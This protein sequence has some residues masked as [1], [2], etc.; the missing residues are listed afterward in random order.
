MVGPSLN[1]KGGMASLLYI[2]NRYY[3]DALNL[4]FI[5]TYFGEGRMKD[6]LY[7]ACAIIR[8]FCICLLDKKVCFHIHVSSG[9][10]YVRKSIIANLCI[11]FGNK[12]VLHIHAG[13]FHDFLENRSDSSK[14]KIIRLL[15]RID[16]IIVLSN[17]WYQYI[18]KYISPERVEIIENPAVTLEEDRT[19]G[20]KP[21]VHILFVGDIC[22]R[23]GVYDLVEAV[24]CLRYRNIKVNIYGNGDAGDLMEAIRE[25]EL[26]DIVSFRGWVPYACIGN[27]Y[28][29]TDIFVLPSY[30]EGLPMSILEAMGKGIPVISTNIGGIP[31]AVLQGQ[32]GFIVEPG[33]IK[34]LT[35]RLELLIQNEELRSLMGQK[36]RK[37]AEE[38]FSIA[39][40]QN[41]LELMYKLLY[42]A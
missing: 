20:D 19:R 35:E 12:V 5:P 1:S 24:K 41:K 8:V 17:S 38:K 3:K 10:S 42:G 30:M 23:K 2:Y 25:S 11:W 22:K 33:D 26:E 37:I 36:G 18:T 27:I 29:G 7:F 6:I 28:N 31:E 15:G 39:I 9:G 40:I 16:K 32:N 21:D 13:D 14:N 4:G 34:G